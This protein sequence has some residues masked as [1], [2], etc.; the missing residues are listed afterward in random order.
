MYHTVAARRSQQSLSDTSLAL[1]PHHSVPLPAW[2]T[3]LHPRAQQLW[4]TCF[5]KISR[6]RVWNSML[7]FSWNTV[8]RPANISPLRRI[9]VATDTNT[10][11]FKPMVYDVLVASINKHNQPLNH[12]LKTTA[13]FFHSVFRS[14]PLPESIIFLLYSRLRYILSYG[15]VPKLNR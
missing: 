9:R 15:H 5:W 7:P 14:S 11:T 12:V 2:H 6:T 13:R 4:T 3:R 1:V 8:G 10:L